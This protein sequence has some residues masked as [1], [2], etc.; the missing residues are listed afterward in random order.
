MRAITNSSPPSEAMS[1]PRRMLGLGAG[2]V[3]R[4]ASSIQVVGMIRLVVFC[5]KLA[6]IRA[7]AKGDCSPSSLMMSA[8][9][10]L[11]TRWVAMSC[12][13]VVGGQVVQRP[14]GSPVKFGVSWAEILMVL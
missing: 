8:T 4:V 11:S 10:C 2:L 6:W 1:T 13:L 3:L 14:V 12:F 7:W 5:T 9:H